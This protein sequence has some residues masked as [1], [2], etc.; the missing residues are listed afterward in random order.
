MNTIHLHGALALYGGPYTMDVSD[1]REAIKA[2]SVQLDGFETMVARGVWRVTHTRR[3]KDL[4]LDDGLIG[5]KISNGEIHF[6]PAMSGSAN[7]QKG[8]GVMKAVAGIALVGLAVITAGAAA[9]LLAGQLTAAGT[10]MGAGAGVLGA[11]GITY[12]TLATFGVMM[13]F[14]GLAL[15][16]AASPSAR[17][18]NDGEA[19]KNSFLFNGPINVSEQGHPIP[20]IYGHIRVGSIAVSSDLLVNEVS[21]YSGGTYEWTPNDPYWPGSGEVVDNVL[22]P[23]V[24]QRQ[25]AY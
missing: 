7:G 1:A 12:G 13:A 5:L 8:K 17:D 4:D 2:L 16:L 10:A 22:G 11:V 3:G 24:T 9:P 6:R 21:V 25:E 18:P 23:G 20:L 19:E 14:G 15:G